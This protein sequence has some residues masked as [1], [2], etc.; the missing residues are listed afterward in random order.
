M[1]AGVPAEVLEGALV[2]LEELTQPLIGERANEASP[3][4]SERQHEQVLHHVALPK[5]HP[6]LPPVDLALLTWRRLE[7]PLGQ[8]RL[9]LQPAKRAH[10]ALHRLVTSGVP[11]SRRNSW[12]RIRAE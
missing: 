10:K 8:L 4:E 12:Y 6:G 2:R 9:R 5:P 3:R 7:A 11:R 1:F